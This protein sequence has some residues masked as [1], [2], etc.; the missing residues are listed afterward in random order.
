M[1]SGNEVAQ[2]EYAGF[3]RR[4]AAYIVDAIL[5]N[6]VSW[7]LEMAIIGALVY[8]GASQSVTPFSKQIL[9]LAISSIAELIYY[10]I[11]THRYATTLGKRIFHIYVF[12]M[13]S[14]EKLTLWKSVVRA[15]GSSVSAIIF[16]AG[17]LMVA[18]HPKKRALH[19][20]MAGSISVKMKPHVTLS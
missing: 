16:G 1:E 2:V 19:D 4:L 8:A 9:F 6:F 13:N 17:Y 11:A 15:L 18:F 10:V 12:D 5:L 14:G 20:L 3:W 7:I